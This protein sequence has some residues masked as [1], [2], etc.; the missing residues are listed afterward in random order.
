LRHGYL[1]QTT[2]FWAMEDRLFIAME[3][4]DGSLRD[5]YRESRGQ[6]L[7]GI[8]VEEL[9]PYIEQS[10]S[11]L[12][13]L[14]ENRLLHRD[15]KPENILRLGKVAKVADFGLAMVLPETVRSV[16]VNSAGTIPYMG[17]EVW[18]GKA[19]EASDQWSLA[20]TY[21]E[22]RAGRTLFSG[23][24]QAEMMFAILNT[25]PELAGLEPA[26]QD[27]LNTA[28]S[29]DHTNRWTCCSE[30][31]EALRLAL[32]PVLPSKKTS[33]VRPRITPSGLRKAIEPA[34]A[35]PKPAYPAA[36][37]A[38][39][40]QVKTHRGVASPTDEM[41]VPPELR[42]TNLT[43]V[44]GNE[45][46]SDTYETKR[47]IEPP[48]AQKKEPPPWQ[49]ESQPE[50]AVPPVL[51]RSS[52]EIPAVRRLSGEHRLPPQKS[53]R[54]PVFVLL[55]VLVCLVSG[56]GALV[57][58][59]SGDTTPSGTAS[60]TDSSTAALADARKNQPPIPD[61]KP[62]E[63]DKPKQP[64]KPPA[65]DL[66]DDQT[67]L[68]ALD[69]LPGPDPAQ[70]KERLEKVMRHLDRLA[71]QAS[72]KLANKGGLPAALKPYADYI[73]A[74]GLATQDR[75]EAAMRMAAALDGKDRPPVLEGDPK[76][77]QQAAQ[78][79][80][81]PLAA[82]RQRQNYD[83]PFAD[84]AAGEAFGWLPKAVPW[85]QA[86][87]PDDSVLASL[88]LNAALAAW[89]G[90]PKGADDARR[91]DGLAAG[92]LPP[93]DAKAISPVDL[94]ALWLARARALQQIPQKR[95]AYDAYLA[96]RNAAE[97]LP[98]D[99]ADESHGQEVTLLT[100]IVEPATGLGKDLAR[101][102]D[103]TFRAQFAKLC[104]DEAD[105]IR[106]YRSAAWPFAKEALP[107][108]LFDLY[109]LAQRNDP[110][111]AEY[112]AWRGTARID[113]TDRDGD[114]ESIRGD[115]N[116]A[117][118]INDKYPRAW[119]LRG[120]AN[121]QQARQQ[122]RVDN[123][124]RFLKAAVD[125]Y[126]TAIGLLKDNKYKE[127]D[128]GPELLTNRSRAYM[129]LGNATANPKERAEYLKRALE[130]AQKA[131]ADHPQAEQ[132]DQALG[133]ALEDIGLL[134]ET[135]DVER[136]QEMYNRA[137]EA[138]G[139]AITRQ[140]DN[141]AFSLD[142]AR[143][144]VRL[145]KNAKG[146]ANYLLPKAKDD[147]KDALEKAVT[148][149]DRV[150]AHDELARIA[151]LE[152]KPEEAKKQLQEAA[153]L[154]DPK[155]EGMVVHTLDW[156]ETVKQEAPQ[157]KT[158]A[159][160]AQA[161]RERMKVVPTDTADRRT[162]RTLALGWSYEVEHDPEVALK[163]FDQILP[164]DLRRA[165]PDDLPVLLARGQLQLD[166][167][168]VLKPSLVEVC[169]AAQRAVELAEVRGAEMDLALAN[170]FLGAAW[171]EKAQEDYAAFKPP[172][173]GG[174]EALREALRPLTEATGWSVEAFQKALAVPLPVKGPGVVWRYRMA[175]N[176]NM[177]GQALKVLKEKEADIC[178]K[179]KAARGQLKEA[180]ELL[181]GAD[182]MTEAQVKQL[183]AKIDEELGKL[184]R[185]FPECADK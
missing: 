182:D 51:R 158:A 21:V 2:S 116:N 86:G 73:V 172:Q 149:L 23:S 118:D 102:G 24:N 113:L 49:S 119:Y 35:V 110:R 67:L 134:V 176:L 166:H 103:P 128:I 153:R 175:C 109:D 15:I 121:H 34:P 95:A 98:R 177:Q 94:A 133:H 170:G 145:V 150:K 156:A 178:A 165:T 117:K 107:R 111:K 180:Q 30:F 60:S 112:Y 96:A 120:Y 135:K 141:P 108:K 26:E 69:E 4:A 18:Y 9:L 148:D 89:Y 33:G 58:W 47:H 144:R 131:K 123:R 75:R 122:A 55:G 139:Q 85:V 154:I 13:Y 142:R 162:A 16:T 143:V 12:D 8:P 20:V 152:G 48:P 106:K 151:L 173:A 160:L 184:D 174:K 74:V 22:L 32:A 59:M 115:A 114:L 64:E 62:P 3:L 14:H 100:A 147:L 155:S 5:R 1:L 52:K 41:E 56:V 161:V 80:L 66:S 45:P 72:A 43:P 127:D 38:V 39:H 136:R 44:S 126:T 171:D 7:P 53:S 25:P 57:W 97:V 77:S 37:S 163:E 157:G 82:S 36:E 84:N 90:G 71:P 61:V 138:F 130:D 81:A 146:D 140:P 129:E 91:V 28:L 181:K 19:C 50:P 70:A 31:T 10:A 63:G 169:K 104:S 101:A 42:H 54:A 17:P 93:R 185:S 164:R 88:R 83:N 11:A 125:D 105:L 167:K 124:P 46:T 179:V 132:V 76:R 92:L 27:V 137:V 29:K 87:L 6:G 78:I 79:L 168:Q 159:L 40:P 99:A 65:P 68:A 183:N